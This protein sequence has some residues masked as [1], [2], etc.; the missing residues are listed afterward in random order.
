MKLA[1]ITMDEFARMRETIKSV[2][3]PVGVVEQ[4]GPHLPLGLDAMHAEALALETSSLHEC[5]VAPPLYYGLC[6]STGSH[7]GT[8]GISPLVL[9]NLV[10]DIGMGFFK[11]QIECLCILTGHAGGTHQAML[12]NA[13]ESLLN[14]SDLQVAV[15]NV[16]DLL[17]QAKDFLECPGDSH[18]GEVETSLAMH[19]WPEMVKGSAPEAYPTYPKFRLVRD[20]V[21][22]WPTGVWGDPSKASPEKGGKIL[23]SEAEVLAAVLVDLE[24][25]AAQKQD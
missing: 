20:K 12:I 9:E 25:H 23:K 1:E 4:H 8:V 14:D 15:V 17:E 11:Q 21:K 16:L 3:L 2:I 6:R 10:Y 18:A 24:K 7:Q 19:L 5:F 22:H 13:G